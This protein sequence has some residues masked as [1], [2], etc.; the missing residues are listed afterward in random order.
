[1]TKYIH[2]WGYKADGSAR[3]FALTADEMLPDEW[4]EK[5]SV[6]DDPMKRTAEWV[7]EA[8]GHT[9]R[10][11]VRPVYEDELDE[12]DSGEDVEVEKNSKPTKPVKPPKV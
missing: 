12:D 7:T 8:A 4:S 6:I 3:V 5:L 10:T 11:P 1:M 9:C 2:V